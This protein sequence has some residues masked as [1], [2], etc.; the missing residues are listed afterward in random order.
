MRNL[1]FVDYK[2]TLSGKDAV[3]QG[4]EDMP[5][6]MYATVDDPGALT[7]DS[8]VRIDLFEAENFTDGT[9]MRVTDIIGLDSDRIDELVSDLSQV[10]YLGYVD[11]IRGEIRQC[12]YQLQAILTDIQKN[13]PQDERKLHKD[14]QEFLFGIYP[15]MVNAPRDPVKMIVRMPAS[16][17]PLREIKEETFHMHLTW[18]PH[19]DHDSGRLTQCKFNSTVGKV[20]DEGFGSMLR[21]MRLTREQITAVNRVLFRAFEIYERHLVAIDVD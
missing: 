11:E 2:R 9:E 13:G 18:Q 8:I 16:G 15:R 3:N 4:Y 5:V 20:S 17:E 1:L 21:S 10:E 14:V 6:W 19:E 12:F 7:G